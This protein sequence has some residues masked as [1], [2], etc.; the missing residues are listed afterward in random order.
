MGDIFSGSEIAELGVQVEVNGRDFYE[1]LAKR[2]KNKKAKAVFKMLALEEE[3]HIAKFRKMLDYFHKYEPKEAYPTEYFSY[4][5]SLASECVFTQ[6]AKGAEIAKNTRD[7]K[8]AIEIGIGF[9]RDSIRL[10]EGMRKV[11]PTEGTAIVD[12]LIKQE[13]KHINKLE[14]LKKGV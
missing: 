11:V 8:D 1:T 3:K 4:L 2:T 6:K 5:N 7:D 10:F 12:I 13:E 9:E 14:A